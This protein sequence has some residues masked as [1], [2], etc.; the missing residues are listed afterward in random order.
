MRMLSPLGSFDDE[1]EEQ[2]DDID[3]EGDADADD[4]QDGERDYGLPP[5]PPSQPYASSNRIFP[6]FAPASPGSTSLS[7]W[8]SSHFNSRRRVLLHF[9][10]D[11]RG[12]DASSYKSDNSSQQ[13][14]PTPVNYNS[15]INNGNN[16]S[17]NTSIFNYSTNTNSVYNNSTN[18]NN[19]NDIAQDGFLA[20]AL[21]PPS[22]GTTKT[23]TTTTTPDRSLVHSSNSTS[24][25]SEG[26]RRRIES[27]LEDLRRNSQG[28]VQDSSDTANL[29]FG[30]NSYFYYLGN[31]K[32]ATTID[33]NGILRPHGTTTSHG[34][35][36]LPLLMPEPSQQAPPQQSS[37]QQTSQPQPQ[38]S[39]TC[40][41]PYL[42]SRIASMDTAIVQNTASPDGSLDPSSQEDHGN[43]NSND[44]GKGESA[45]N[46]NSIDDNIQLP[47]NSNVESV[48]MVLSDDSGD[49]YTKPLLTDDNDDS[50]A[51]THPPL[52][53]EEKML[54]EDELELNSPRHDSFPV[55]NVHS[56]Q[57]PDILTTTAATNDVQDDGRIEM[58]NIPLPSSTSDKELYH[59]GSDSTDYHQHLENSGHL[60]QLSSPEVSFRSQGQSRTEFADATPTFDWKKQAEIENFSKFALGTAGGGDSVTR[61]N[62]RSSR[63]RRGS[64]TIQRNS[65]ARFDSEDSSSVTSSGLSPHVLPSSQPSSPSMRELHVP[66]AQLPEPHWNMPYRQPYQQQH[67]Q[68][69]SAGSMPWSPQTHHQ[70]HHHHHPTGL[71]PMGHRNHFHHQP[72][73]S[74][75]PTWHHNVRDIDNSSRYSSIPSPRSQHGVDGQSFVSRNLSPQSESPIFSHSAGPPPVPPVGNSWAYNSAGS[76]DSAFSW[77]SAKASRVHSETSPLIADRKLNQESAPSRGTSNRRFGGDSSDSDDNGTG[78]SPLPKAFFHLHHLSPL[79]KPC[80]RQ[81]VDG[82][83]RLA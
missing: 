80:E 77:L 71:P 55:D 2:H 64:H 9:S 41:Q 30:S 33:F 54:T 56:K 78:E 6:S 4:E 48:V 58:E 82:S 24:P 3:D 31:P 20:S 61:R 42:H 68:F 65:S 14:M 43:V 74:W 1:E 40:E 34:Q 36:N 60:D 12:A 53:W 44:K 38:S 28:Q 7:S 26:Q 39:E 45:K 72:S 52:V 10:P 67:P 15:N 47:R 13:R 18:Y 49:D 19:S 50:T 83:Y 35:P 69:R 21:I 29:S 73:P 23:T 51:S 17:S 79:G 66:M 32:N 76:F 57:Q 8:E 63:Q 5:P 46:S 75:S 25:A 11:P 59:D 70:F 22:A 37:S 16:S 62:S 81:I 27:F